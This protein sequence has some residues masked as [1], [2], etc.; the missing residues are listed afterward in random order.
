MI[1]VLCIASS[2]VRAFSFLLFVLFCNVVP[3]CYQLFSKLEGWYHNDCPWSYI[4][5]W[6]LSLVLFLVGVVVKSTSVPEYFF[7]GKFD[8]VGSSHQLWHLTINLAFVF[9]T[10][11]PWRIYVDWRA[12]VPC[13]APR[14][15][16]LQPPSPPPFSAS[17][18]PY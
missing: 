6:A 11:V 4:Y 17:G 9:G 1:A 8:F 5:Y 15:L 13:P 12:Q 18:W 2:S 3:L 7:P 10:L 14:E 16:F